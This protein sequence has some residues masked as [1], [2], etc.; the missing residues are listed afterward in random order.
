M[1]LALRAGVRP[2]DRGA[3]RH[4]V[5]SSGFFADSEEE[6]AVELVEDALAKGEVGSG[7]HFL[8]AEDSARVWGLLHDW[9]ENYLPIGAKSR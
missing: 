3:V 1:T 7:Y 6:I 8:F 5:A 2:E 4:L 9:L